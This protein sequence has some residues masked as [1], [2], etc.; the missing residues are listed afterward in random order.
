[1]NGDALN[2]D[3]DAVGRERLVLD[4]PGRLAVHRV[5]EFCSELLK[6]DLVHAT[7]DLL[8]RS[9]QELDRPVPDVRIIDQQLRRRHDLGE[10]GLVVGAKQRRAVGRDDVVADLVEQRGIVA[11]PDDLSRIA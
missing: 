9:E 1:M 10:P 7:A 5:A 8:I 4:M 2:G 11:D 3:L 6:I